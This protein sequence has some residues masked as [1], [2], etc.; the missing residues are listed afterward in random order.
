MKDLTENYK[1]TINRLKHAII[2]L[3]GTMDQIQQENDD[4]KQ[5]YEKNKNCPIVNTLTKRGQEYTDDVR[6]LYYSL[7]SQQIAPDRIHIPL[8]N[9]YCKLSQAIIPVSRPW[10]FPKE[11]WQ[12]K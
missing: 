6:K 8:S 7:L 11:P 10:N 12:T 4:L 5:T 1:K 3:T 2:C 9:L